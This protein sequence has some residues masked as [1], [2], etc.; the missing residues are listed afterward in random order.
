MERRSSTRNIAA[1]NSYLW[2]FVNKIVPENQPGKRVRKDQ[3]HYKLIIISELKF[4]EWTGKNVL[5]MAPGLAI[6]IAS[7]A[8]YNKSGGLT[9]AED[10]L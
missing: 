4:S 7:Y 3:N 10:A 2:L 5:V 8:G 1:I 6:L 9:I